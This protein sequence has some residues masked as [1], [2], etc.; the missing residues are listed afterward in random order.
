MLVCGSEWGRVRDYACHS[1]KDVYYQSVVIAKRSLLRITAAYPLGHTILTS[2]LIE[3]PM[4]R[5]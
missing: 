3:T 2:L 1:L 4:L 5:V